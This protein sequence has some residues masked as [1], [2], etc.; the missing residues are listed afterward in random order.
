MLRQAVVGLRLVAY[1]PPDPLKTDPLM[2]NIKA[3]SAKLKPDRLRWQGT[4]PPRRKPASARDK[5]AMF[6]WHVATQHLLVPARVWGWTCLPV[7][8]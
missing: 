1:Y 4:A 5:E 8:L 3:E 2:L 7:L 6:G